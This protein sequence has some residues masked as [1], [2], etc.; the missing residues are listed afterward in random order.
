MIPADNRDIWLKVG[1][2]LHDLAK[3]DPRWAGPVRAL[4]D[5]WSKTC[6]EKFNQPGQEKTWASFGRDL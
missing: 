1:C 3:D 6:P 5:E 2:A 4:W